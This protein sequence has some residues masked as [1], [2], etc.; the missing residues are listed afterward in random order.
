MA[1]EIG[2]AL[3]TVMQTQCRLADHPSVSIGAVLSAQDHIWNEC[4]PALPLQIYN[5]L[6]SGPLRSLLRLLNLLLEHDLSTTDFYFAL[7]ATLYI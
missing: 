6:N 3:P 4:N 5:N 7:L 1:L 2:F